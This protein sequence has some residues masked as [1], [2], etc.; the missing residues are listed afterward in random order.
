MAKPFKTAKAIA[1]GAAVAGAAGYVAGLL[2][3]PQS[4]KKTRREFIK[5]AGDNA[6][7]VEKQLE[8]LHGELGN[9]V[10]EAKGRGDDLGSKAQK[11]LRKL[12]DS[13]RDSKDKAREVMGAL[14][15]GTASDKD[16]KNAIADAKH[17]VDHI[18]DY[19][20]K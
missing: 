16:L 8:A 10:D 6:S 14:Q 13:A 18:K 15:D 4:G 3:A 17:T 12:V 9:L 19:L 7:S 2:T 20:K 11:E 1:I 5:S